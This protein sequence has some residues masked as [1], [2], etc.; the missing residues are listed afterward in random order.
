M[1]FLNPLGGYGTLTPITSLPVAL[2]SAGTVAA[3]ESATADATPSV[4]ALS[5]TP[6]GHA[7]PSSGR[8]RRPIVTPRP[9]ARLY[10]GRAGP[11]PALRPRARVGPPP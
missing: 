4:D 2:M 1:W 10:G 8:P 7:S 3:F 6:A 11:L 5:A 9:N